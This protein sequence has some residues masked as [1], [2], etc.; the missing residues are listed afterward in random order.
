M[1][2][3]RLYGGNH[4]PWVQA[5]MLGLHEKAIDYA[6]STVPA[7]EA[8]LRWGVWMPAASFDGEPWQIESSEILK[9]IGF[10]EVSE[11]DL[12]A[13]HREGCGQKIVPT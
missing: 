3:I 2:D 7:P 13:V 8:F 10:S 5:V 1:A 11:E 6:H 4:S 12:V 9:K